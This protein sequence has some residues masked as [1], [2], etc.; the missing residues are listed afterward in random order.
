[1]STVVEVQSWVQISSCRVTEAELRRQTGLVHALVGLVDALARL[2]HL[3]CMGNA[4]S[5]R[6]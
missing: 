3:R 4:V 2:G 6:L 5:E 1:V